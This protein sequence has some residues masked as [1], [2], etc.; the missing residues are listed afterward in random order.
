M[1]EYNEIKEGRYIIFED[2]PYEVIASHVFRKQQRKP[3]NATKLRH[4]VSGR[5]IEHSFH[6]SDKVHHADIAKKNIVY[7]YARGNEFWFHEEDNKSARFTLSAEQIGDQARFLKAD[8]LVEALTFSGDIVGIQLP[9]KVDLVVTEAPPNVKGDSS[10]GGNKVVTLETGATI[11]AP[12]FI[13]VGDVITVNTQ[14]GEYAER[15][16]KN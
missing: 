12:L 7:I 5:M 1:L 6:Q 11:T 2:D 14:T 9:I 3:V 10:R 8:A 13:N 16:D 4:L 15:A